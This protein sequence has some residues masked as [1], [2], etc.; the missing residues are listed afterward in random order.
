MRQPSEP[1]VLKVAALLLPWFL[2][3]CASPPTARQTRSERQLTQAV[4][5]LEQRSDADSLAAAAVVLRFA[6]PHS[7]VTAAHALLVRAVT[8]APERADLAWLEIQMCREVSGCDSEPEELHLRALDPSNGAA[9]L[10]ALARANASNDEAAR[11]AVLSALARTERVDLYWNTLT[12]HLTRALADTRKVPL[13]EALVAVIGILAAEAIPAYSATSSLCKG[14][15]LND[16]EVL[17]SCRR[18]ALAFERGDTYITELMGGGI[19][20]RLWPAE[21]LEWKAAAE[22]RRVFEYRSQL[23]MQSALNARHDARWA[24][25]YLAWC[26]QY[27]REQDVLRAELIDEGKSPD[28]PVSAHDPGD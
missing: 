3:G 8:V 4:A 25:Q 23:S 16:V 10:N 28:P 17:E 1:T 14:D 22:Q 9:G 15:R 27:H 12:L 2:V 13:P 11:I 7:D 5:V 18:V 26:A 21:S 24:E 6:R 19:A 20:Q